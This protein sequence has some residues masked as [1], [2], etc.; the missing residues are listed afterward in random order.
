M[1]DLQISNLSPSR[2]GDNDA[3]TPSTPT[4]PVWATVSR[5]RNINPKVLWGTYPGS[6]SFS[7]ML[8][9]PAILRNHRLPGNNLS[10]RSPLC[11]RQHSGVVQ[12]IRTPSLYV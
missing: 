2:L 12:A 1:F 9:F 4:K 6:G 5:G 8:G 7:W 10:R 3:S 11:L